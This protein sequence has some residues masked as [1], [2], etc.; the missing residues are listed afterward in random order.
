MIALLDI[1]ERIARVQGGRRPPP[2]STRSSAGRSSSR[3][4]TTRWPGSRPSAARREAADADDAPGALAGLQILIAEDN[5]VNQQVLLRQ[6]Q[7]LGIVAEAVENGAEVLTAL[8][9]RSYDAILMDCQMPVMDGY[10]ATRAIRERE[11]RR[12]ARMPI[13]AVTANAMREDFERCREAGMDDFVAKPVDARRARERDRAGRQREPRHA[14][15]RDARRRAAQPP[16]GGVDMAALAVAAGGPRRARRAGADRA[17]VPRAAR[18]AGR[19]DRR[20]RARRRARVA[21][22]HR[23]PHAFE[24]GDARRDRD[25]GPARRARGRGASTAMPRPAT[26]SPPTFAAQV[27]TTRAT[28]E[29]VLAELDAVVSADG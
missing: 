24:R 27:A 19:A 16:A 22:A 15:P 8:E 3:A 11:Q 18:P 9:R 21:R 1:G 28:F 2:T 4:S 6:V 14:A 7:R 29:P 13:V 20:E 23:P 12:A 26:S 17:A 5:P 25:G 10:E